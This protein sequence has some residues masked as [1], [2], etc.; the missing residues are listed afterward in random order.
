MTAA[1]V[2]S[3]VLPKSYEVKTTIFIEQNVISD[4]VKGIAVSPS[5]QAKI[6]TLTVTLT[7]RNLLLQVLKNL[8]KDLSF[9]NTAALE[10]YIKDMQQ[11]IMV[12]L[13]ERQGVFT[14][15]VG[16]PIQPMPGIRQRHGQGVHRAQHL[17]QA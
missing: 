1:V 9:E 16:T 8:D 4:L 6:K 2:V 13:N 7:S 5:A 3:Y 14:I 15:S 11:R 17:H 10:A 12:N